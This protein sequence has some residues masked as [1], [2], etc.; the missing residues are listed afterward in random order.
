MLKNIYYNYCCIDLPS[1][2][3]QNNVDSGND[4]VWIFQ[5]VQHVYNESDQ[6]L[7][8]CL[9]L[10]VCRSSMNVSVS[11]S[12]SDIDLPAFLLREDNSPSLF[13]RSEVNLLMSF[14]NSANNSSIERSL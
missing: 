5:N 3:I 12:N 13:S 6:T 4:T 9:F 2:E 14:I 7:L 11:V 8:T 10:V 1:E